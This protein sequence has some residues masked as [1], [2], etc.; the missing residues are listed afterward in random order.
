MALTTV[1]K[2]RLAADLIAL[3]PLL[4]A[5]VILV[6][7]SLPND[8]SLPGSCANHLRTAMNTSPAA[9][10]ALDAPRAISSPNFATDL[11]AH[12]RN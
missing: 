2:T 12:S 11:E 3:T 8:R 4:I 9:V 5:P 6:I 7:A 1:S 10:P